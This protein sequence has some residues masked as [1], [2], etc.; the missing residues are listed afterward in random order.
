MKPI[1]TSIFDFPTLIANG[2][3][4]VDVLTEEKMDRSWK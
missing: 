1:N 4:Y 3:V 2:Y